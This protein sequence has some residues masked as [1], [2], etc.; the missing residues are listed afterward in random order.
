MPERGDVMDDSVL[1]KRLGESAQSL[2]GIASTTEQGFLDVG[3]TLQ[4]LSTRLGELA[5]R[6]LKVRGLTTGGEKPESSGFREIFAE[7]YSKLA[8]CLETIRSGLGGLEGLAEGVLGFSTLGE[9]LRKLSKTV[10][11]I[12]LL[13]RI[14]TSRTGG[15]GSELEVMSGTVVDLAEQVRG[16]ANLISQ[17]AGSV[18]ARVQEIRGELESSLGRIEMHL[19]TARDRARAVIDEVEAAAAEDFSACA[20][21]EGRIGL[22]R[23]SIGEVVTT[24]QYHDICRQQLEHV[25]AVFDGGPPLFEDGTE[26]S[27]GDWASAVLGIQQ[28]QLEHVVAVATD[29]AGQIERQLALMGTLAGELASDAVLMI[30]DAETGLTRKAAVE[31]EVGSAERALELMQSTT[32]GAIESLLTVG[33]LVDTIS[34]Q[35]GQVALIS[36]DLNLLAQNAIVKAARAGSSGRALGVLAEEVSRLSSSA[37]TEIDM[38]TR[39]ISEV[40]VRS[41]SFRDDLATGLE[42]H[43]DTLDKAYSQARAAVDGLLRRHEDTARSMNSFF[44]IAKDLGDEMARVA[45]G[46]GFHRTVELEVG[47]VLRELDAIFDVLKTESAL[48]G[49]ELPAGYLEE[50]QRRYTMESERLV[51]RGLGPLRAETG[52]ALGDNVELF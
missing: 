18:H 28:S 45:G 25:A 1:R 36:D 33:R 4:V 13:I 2:A 43:L 5:E 26:A 3:A 31:A 32:R 44:Q 10:N 35:V 39:Q 12:G 37:K 16:G 14:E 30:Q 23:A 42:R 41:E 19:S 20:R 51:H 8:D 46:F 17:S 34:D 6:A 15:A 27:F 52:S 22:L 50:L 49:V 24:L 29:V 47:A 48:H 9:T 21:C 40:I 38:G 11:T 7:V